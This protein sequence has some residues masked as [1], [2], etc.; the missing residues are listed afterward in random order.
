MCTENS[1]WIVCT[2]IA[3]RI[4][5]TEIVAR[6]VRI[7]I[8]ARIVS[9][10]I[11]ARIVCTKIAARIVSTKIA[12]HTMISRL[13][14][15]KELK[16]ADSSTRVI[17]NIL[18]LLLFFF[19]RLIYPSSAGDTTAALREAVKYPFRVGVAKLLVLLPCSACNGD[20]Y[21][22]AQVLKSHGFMLHV[23]KAQDFKLTESANHSPVRLFGESGCIGISARVILYKMQPLTTLTF[24]LTAWTDPGELRRTLLIA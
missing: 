22:L 20:M 9:S 13:L 19:S 2:E 14:F 16:N 15:Q 8:V 11:A 21:A 3:T 24:F 10:E 23:L 4:V 5:H 17:K 1:A 6:V 12:G 7:E 18:R